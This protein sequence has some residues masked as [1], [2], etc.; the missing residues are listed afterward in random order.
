MGKGAG[1][2]DGGL[3]ERTGD[4]LGMGKGLEEPTGTLVPA[5]VAKGTYC[6][7]SRATSRGGAYD[8]DT[9]LAEGGRYSGA[10]SGGGEDV[11]D[12]TL[13]KRPRSSKAIAGREA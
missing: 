6:W 11:G 5:E 9:T 10:I 2:S 8:G 13:A 3:V 1:I 7:W 12:S 4:R